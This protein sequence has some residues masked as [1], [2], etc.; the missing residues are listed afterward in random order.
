M[1]VYLP[2]NS[3]L[4]ASKYFNSATPIDACASC[5][6]ACISPSCLDLNPST[7]GICESFS[8]SVIGNPSISN[9][10]PTCGPSTPVS[11]TATIPVSP[12]LILSSV[13][14]ST[15]KLSARSQAFN[16]SASDGR[17]I[18]ALM[19]VAS[20]PKYKV[21]EV[22][23]ISFKIKYVVIISVNP[24]SG[25][26]CSVLRSVF[27]SSIKVFICSD[28]LFFIICDKPIHEF[29]TDV[30]F[31]VFK[32]PIEIIESYFNRFTN[33]FFILSQIHV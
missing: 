1:I 17:P 11:S 31:S 3:S 21:N 6:H 9:L 25:Y 24:T 32:H 22:S 23:S 12:F 14:L 16:N 30:I 29:S 33:W 20:L 4:F 18:C 19:S 7:N 8:A 13:S 27:A 15:P 10:N 5:P 26:W 2:F 28:S